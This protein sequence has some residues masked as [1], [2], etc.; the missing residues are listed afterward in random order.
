MKKLFIAFT[1]LYS[2][3]M[4]AQNLPKQPDFA[5]P[6]KVK[7]EAIADY[8]KAMLDNDGDRIVN[9]LVAY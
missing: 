1:I 8:K 7:A 9:S 6:K 5:F 4:N 3:V 2:L